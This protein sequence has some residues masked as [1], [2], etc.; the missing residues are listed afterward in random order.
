MGSSNDSNDVT[1]FATEK[2]LG[3]LLGNFKPTWVT[4]IAGGILAVLAAAGAAALFWFPLQGAYAAH[5]KLPFWADRGWC[6]G[7]IG[8][9]SLLCV[10]FA[11]VAVVLAYVTVGMIGLRTAL[12]ERGFLYVSRADQQSVLWSDVTS[13]CETTV[14]ER[15]PILKGPAQLLLPKVTSRFYEIK[16]ADGRGFRFTKDCVTRINEFAQL[17]RQIATNCN[18]AWE[19][20]EMH[21]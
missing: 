18:I 13:I 16:T 19:N 20:E 8:L 10:V 4:V 3:K 14:Y 6:W 17:L 1:L 21:C 2:E 5:W 15:P 7:A 11:G 9:S 12:F